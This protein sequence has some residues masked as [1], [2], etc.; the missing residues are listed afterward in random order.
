M[1][2]WEAVSGWLKGMGEEHVCGDAGRPVF[3]H[4]KTAVVRDGK[5]A[6]DT[7]GRRG[8]GGLRV[9][10]GWYIDCWCVLVWIVG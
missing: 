6:I 1:V 8:D 7:R 2:D 5:P 10:L 4:I 3:F 9:I